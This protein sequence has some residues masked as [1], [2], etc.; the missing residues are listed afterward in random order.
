MM[1][2]TVSHS[3]ER[4]SKQEGIILITTIIILALSTI[5]MLTGM[6]ILSLY[7]KAL[8]QTVE[9]EDVAYGLEAQ[10]N[11]L[12]L[13]DWQTGTDRCLVNEKTPDEIAWL[14]KNRQGCEL[15]Y[16][17]HR[18]TYLVEDLGLFPCLQT[19]INEVGHSTRHLR[20]SVLG[21]KGAFLQLRVARA[22][23]LISCS[24]DIIYLKPGVISWRYVDS[25]YNSNVLI[26]A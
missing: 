12:A 15:L 10:A 11:Q 19:M 21:D 13:R 4:E 2:G 26:S 1:M 23:P 7:Y 3:R 22:A 25:F 9:K 16:E 6:Q 18:Y 24:E 20:I 8:N 14:L 17:G 5:L